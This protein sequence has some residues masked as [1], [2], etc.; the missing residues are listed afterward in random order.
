MIYWDFVVI[1]VFYVAF[2]ETYW[3]LLFD[4]Q[5]SKIQ[6]KTAV[7][8]IINWYAYSRSHRIDS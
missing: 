7:A 1:Y 5:A 6:S 4:C 8:H 2:A 3:I